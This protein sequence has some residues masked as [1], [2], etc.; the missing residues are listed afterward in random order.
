ML[1]NSF[2]VFLDKSHFQSKRFVINLNFNVS[3]AYRILSTLEE[4]GYVSRL[5]NKDYV[6][7]TQ[8]LYLSAFIRKVII[9]SKFAQ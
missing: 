3:T 6:I 4:Y 9:L 2:N 8:A 5:K 1:T 7:G